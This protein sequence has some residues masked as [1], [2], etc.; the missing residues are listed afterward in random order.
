MHTLYNH[1]NCTDTALW[2]CTTI[3]ISCMFCFMYVLYCTGIV[4][5]QILIWF[6]SFVL[7]TKPHFQTFNALKKHIFSGIS[8]FLFQTFSHRRSHIPHCI[9][10]YSTIICLIFMFYTTWTLTFQS[11]IYTFKMILLSIIYVFLLKCLYLLC[12]P[13]LLPL[14]I[15]LKPIYTQKDIWHVFFLFSF[16]EVYSHLFGSP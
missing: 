12:Q 8:E 13:L 7:F 16:S 9:C 10:M 11:R 1:L 4:R 14:W 15:F 2:L 6:Q 3:I 5:V